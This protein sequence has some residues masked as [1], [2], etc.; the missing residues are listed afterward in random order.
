MSIDSFYKQSFTIVTQ[1]PATTFPYDLVET[2]G[3]TFKG[4]L[5]TVSSADRWADAQL[6]AISSH[7]IATKSS[8]AVGK[9]ERIKYGT[10]YFEVTGIPDPVSLKPNH[11]Q[12]IY[13]KEVTA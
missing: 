12:E 4:A 10:R 13:C 1:A 5:D 3:A 9:G 2:A 6:V 7:W 8:V 11:H